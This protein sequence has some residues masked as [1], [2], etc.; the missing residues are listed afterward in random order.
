MRTG[1][2]GGSGLYEIE[3]I[4]VLDRLN[5]D[6][7]YGPASDELLLANI[8]GHE[9]VFLPRHGRSHHFPPHRINYRANIYAMKLAGV[10]QII[11]VSAVGSLRKE[12][13]PGHFV[14][15]D[16]FV[17]RTHSRDSTFFDGPVVAHVSMADP[18]CS[19][20]S[21]RLSSAC[22]TA[23][24]TLH[25][26]GS[27][28]V[29]QG[30]QFS[31]RAESGLYRSWGMDVIGMT[32]LP[33]AKLAREAEICYATVAMSTDYDCWHEEEEDVNVASLLEV[34]QAN[35]QNAQHMLK[36]YFS[37]LNVKEGLCPAGCNA[38]LENAIFADLRAQDDAAITPVHAL[39]ERFL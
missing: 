11:S 5:I 21:S 33:E 24:I 7:P 32:N 31:S 6:T 27:Y 29:M 13:A 2:I 39:I 25:K 23:G 16:Q 12:I 30:P 9:A 17:D 18:V 36:Q 26:G 14:L 8:H 38:A 22:K 37:N 35:V 10:S 1:I 20:L 28:L 34:M 3:G 4:E 15:I 19:R